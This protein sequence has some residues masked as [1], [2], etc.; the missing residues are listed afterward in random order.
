[1]PKVVDGLFRALQF[2][3]PRRIR[4]FRAVKNFWRYCMNRNVA[5]RTSVLFG[6]LGFAALTACSDQPTQPKAA[7][8]LA[9]RL[10]VPPT[11]NPVLAKRIANIDPRVL[12]G[13][14]YNYFFGRGILSRSG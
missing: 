10:A 3:R 11:M 4:R 1:M 7:P 5:T 8:E 6:A 14:A 13:A 2:I 12:S 9:P